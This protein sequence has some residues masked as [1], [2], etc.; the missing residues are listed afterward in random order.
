MED[1]ILQSQYKYNKEDYN[2]I[3]VYY[4]KECL[5]LLIWTYDINT[6]YCAKCGNTDIG[7]TTIDLWEELYEHK[8]G[9]K[10]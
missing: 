6:D 1:G 7:V 8:Y 2:N 10:F 3:P 9:K 5:S 4:C